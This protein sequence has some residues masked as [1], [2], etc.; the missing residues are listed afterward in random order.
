MSEQHD[1]RLARGIG[2]IVVCLT[3]CALFAAWMSPVPYVWG[4]IAAAIMSL[5]LKLGQEVGVD[6]L[7][8]Y[9]VS[10]NPAA[11]IL[12]LTATL[13]VD[14]LML[15]ASHRLSMV[16]LLKGNVIEEVAKGLPEDIQLIIHS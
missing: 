1:E 9:A 16:R 12:D 5:L 11:T 10:T 13:G 14:F 8:V 3:S 2:V 7:P 6:V 4:A 15:G